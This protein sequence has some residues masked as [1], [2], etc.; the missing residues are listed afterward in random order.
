MSRGT[1]SARRLRWSLAAACALSLGASV[2]RAQAATQANDEEYTRKIREYLQDPRITTE[3]VDHLPASSTVPTPLKFLGRIVGTPGELTYAKDIHR[4]LEAIAKASPRAKYWSIGKTEEGRDMVVLAVADEQTIRQLDQNKAMLNQ[5]TDPRKTSEAEAQR[6][7]GTAK[8]IYW[9][10]SGMHSPER[11]GPEMLMELAYRLAVEETPFIQ[12]IRNNV[13]TFIT[14]VIEVDGREK[15]VDTYYWNKKNAPAPAAGEGGGGRGGAANQLPLMYWGKYVQHDNNRDGMGQYLA[16]TKHTTKTF[17]DWTPTVLHD[18]HEAQTY[19]YSSTGTGPYNDAIDPITIDEWWLLAKNDVMEMTKRGVPGVWTYGFYDGWVPNYMFFIAHTHNAIGRFYE[20]QSYGPENYEVRPAATV[21]SKEWFRPNPPLP[22]IKWG[23]RNNTNIQQSGVLFSLSHVAKNRRTYLENYWLKN[24]RAVAKGRSGPL[25]AWVIPAGQ[26]AKGN[27]AEA[28]ND[29]RRQGLEFHTATSAFKAGNVSVQAGDYIVRGDQPYRTLADMYFSLQ[30]F[31]P[32]NPSPYDDTGWT[33]PLMR[34]LTIAAVTDSAI[35]GQAMKPVT[36]DVTAP[37]GLAGSGR[38][39]VVEHTSDNNLVTFRFKLANVKMQAAEEEFDAAGRH[40]GAGAF[41]IP[42]ANRAQIEPLLKQLGLSGYAMASAPRVKTHDLDVPRIGYVH[43]WTRTQD[44]GWVRASFDHYGVPYTYFGE[45]KLKEGNLRAKYDVI[46][47]PHGGTGL[48]PQPG[49][50]GAGGANAPG[51]TGAPGPEGGPPARPG[52]AAAPPAQGAQSV[53][54]GK[55]IPYKRTAEFQAIGYPD[56]TDDIRGG[57]GV[58]GMKALYE[59]VRQGGTLITEGSTAAIFPDLNLTP[60]VKTETPTS[61]FARGTILRGVIS[62]RRSPLVY[63]YRRPELPVYFNSGPVLNAGAGAPQVASAPD[64]AG[65]R[66]GPGGPAGGPGGGGRNAARP[67]GQNV[68]PMAT[69]LRLSPWDPDSTGRA[70]GVLPMSATDSA[71]RRGGGGGG[72][73]GGGFGGA[74][75]RGPQSVPGLTADANAKTRVVIQ[76]PA[77]PEDMLLSG[78][79]E[80]GATLSSRAQLVDETIGQGHV[81]MFSIRPFWRWQTQGTYFLGF[82]A[83]LNWNDLSAGST[84]APGQKAAM[85][86]TGTK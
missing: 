72:G 53:A 54:A 61:L 18:L 38:V 83:I 71:A 46:V 79:L 51:A 80:G 40:F 23:P 44:E 6:L 81:V 20:V 27:A 77:K 35:L 42:N 1:Q 65:G 69:Q 59:F 31:S 74:G 78:T 39:V 28:V 62:D 68:T 8:P 3:L 22:Y 14:P 10:T 75:A 21:T 4:Y 5:L 9:L 73:G 86:G 52:A 58:D 36:A 63:G 82:N 76:F 64:S 26:H 48:G 50:G 45:P 47:Y 25:Y 33:F 11:G 19:L 70:Y 17:I 30:N 66:G 85:Q 56:S 37:G 24:K 60:G 12:E 15:M 84:P 41:I 2:V 7:L 29:L 57:V 32:A 67:Q 43:S 55:P 34:N 49:Q 13:I 16:L